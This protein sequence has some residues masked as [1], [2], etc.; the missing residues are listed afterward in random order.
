MFSVDWPFVSNKDG[1]D[2]LSNNY[3][4][5]NDREKIFSGNAKK[6]LRI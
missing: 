3:L 6:L 5:A 4:H 2:W 1:V